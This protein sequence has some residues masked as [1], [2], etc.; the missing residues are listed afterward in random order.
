M[1][2]TDLLTP[3][4]CVCST[5]SR[6][7]PV[8]VEVSD[9]M[10]EDPGHSNRALL[11]AVKTRLRVRANEDTTREEQVKSLEKQV[12]PLHQTQLP[13]GLRPFSHYLHSK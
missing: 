6:E 2:A 5:H 7:A 13:Y 3:D 10:T 1:P 11:Y 9:V 12:E 8:S 4:A